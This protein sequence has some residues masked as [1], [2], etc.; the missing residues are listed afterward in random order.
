MRWNGSRV[1]VDAVLIEF[2]LF[3]LIIQRICCQI[4]TQEEEGLGLKEQFVIKRTL[5]RIDVN[6]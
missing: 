3:S 2:H 4:G 1:G 5:W 6:S